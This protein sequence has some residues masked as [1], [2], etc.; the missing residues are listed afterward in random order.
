MGEKTK[1]ISIYHDTCYYPKETEEII[2]QFGQVKSGKKFGYRYIPTVI[3][4]EKP[5]GEV[6]RKPEYK[7]FK[8]PF[9]LH[10][11]GTLI[12]LLEG[13]FGTEF[14]KSNLASVKRAFRMLEN[15]ASPC[16]DRVIADL[17]CQIILYSINSNRGID[18]IFFVEKAAT[19]KML[20]RLGFLYLDLSNVT[21][22]FLSY[23]PRDLMTTVMSSY[24]GK[25][26]FDLHRLL[27]SESYGKIGPYPGSSEDSLMQTFFYRASPIKPP[28][29]FL[30]IRFDI[31]AQGLSDTEIEAKSEKILKILEDSSEI[32]EYPIGEKFVKLPEGFVHVKNAW[33]EYIEKGVKE[34]LKNEWKL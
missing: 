33:K 30:P 5:L 16:A 27:I 17:C 12:S 2:E 19:D 34:T 23:S 15:L 18:L 3:W 4:V 13:Y 7:Y 26:Y 10:E 31:F 6:I 1:I 29:E 20:G 32:I 24:T 21:I 22:C 28:A 25:L 11:S 8:S 14:N 9:S